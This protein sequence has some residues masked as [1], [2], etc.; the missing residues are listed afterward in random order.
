MSW[1]ST[2]DPRRMTV[3]I[4][5]VLA[6]A[7]IVGLGVGVLLGLAGDGTSTSAST[8]STPSVTTSPSAAATTPSESP[9]VRAASEIQDGTTKD[10]GYLVAS[11]SEDD[12]VHVTFDRVVFYT[13]QAARDYARSHHKRPP[14]GNGALIVNDNERKRDLVLSPDIAVLGTR[15][16]AGSSTPTEVSLKTL[17]DAVA[18]QGDRLLLNLRYDPLGYVIKVTEHDLS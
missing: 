1:W 17:R 14:R 18:S 16:L 4:G 6:A 5:V 13:G 7:A 8:S 2:D 15:A 11:R 3:V 9:T 12:G 10:I